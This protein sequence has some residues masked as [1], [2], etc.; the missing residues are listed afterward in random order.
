MVS[1]CNAR[2]CCGP[3]DSPKVSADG[4]GSSNGSPNT[5][6][7]LRDGEAQLDFVK[8]NTVDPRD[9]Q[10]PVDV[11]NTIATAKDAQDIV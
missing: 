11:H 2:T 1:A 8:I 10:L 9:S 5:F 6:K 4:D 3:L 7:R